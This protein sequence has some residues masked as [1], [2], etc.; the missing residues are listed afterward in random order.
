M[1][2]CDADL[3]HTSHIS[4]EEDLRFRKPF[5]GGEGQRHRVGSGCPVT[6]G[7]RLTS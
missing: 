5:R 4:D 6:P 1:A 3:I 7:R 2:V